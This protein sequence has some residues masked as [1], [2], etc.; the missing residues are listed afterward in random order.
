M[1]EHNNKLRNSLGIIAAKNNVGDSFGLDI[2]PKRCEDVNI[3]GRVIYYDGSRLCED[4]ECTTLIT[5]VKLRDAFVSGDLFVV[6][7][8]DALIGKVIYVLG[9]DSDGTTI[10]PGQCVVYMDGELQTFAVDA[11]IQQT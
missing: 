2:I 11:P 5:S 9:G 3:V 6:A 1:N 4:I 8:G 7:T 10:Y